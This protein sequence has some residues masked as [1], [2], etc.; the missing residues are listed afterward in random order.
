MRK[1]RP[2]II[3]VALMTRYTPEPR[4][5]HHPLYGDIPLINRGDRM[6]YDPAYKPDLPKGAVRGDIEVQSYCPMCDIPRYFYVDEERTCVQCGERFVFGAKEQKFWYETLKFNYASTAIRCRRCRRER[7]TEVALRAQLADVLRK[8]EAKP[9]D[10]SLLL[11]LAKTTVEYRERTGEG[12]L[13]RAIAAC[14]TAASE[15]PEDAEPLFWEGR[16]QELAGR[17]AKAQKLYDAFI[18]RAKSHLGK[19]V[20]IAEERRRPAG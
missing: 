8:L 7:R 6:A 1:L 19:L 16:C 10:P 5:V 15:C 17:T 13:N 2:A 12:D 9:R 18:G 20:K 11:E 14:R 4:T 3:V